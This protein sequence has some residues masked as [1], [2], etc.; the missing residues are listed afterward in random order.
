MLSRALGGVVDTQPQSAWCRWL[1]D[2]RC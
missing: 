2:S 1:E